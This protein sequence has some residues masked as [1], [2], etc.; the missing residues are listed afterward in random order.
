[1]QTHNICSWNYVG[2]GK[3]NQIPTVGKYNDISWDYV[4]TGTM[5]QIPTVGKY[6]AISWNYVDTDTMNR[7]PT[8]GKYNAISWNY[9]DTGTMNRPLR[10][11]EWTWTNVP[12]IKQIWRNERGQM[13][14]SL[15]RFG[16]MGTQNIYTNTPVRLIYYANIYTR[17]HQFGWFI[18]QIYISEHTVRRR[19]RFIAP[20]FQ[21]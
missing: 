13:H 4:D 6:N 19:G 18:A 11:T 7:I 20:A 9:V 8:V 17:T 10:L 1:M 14:Q 21:L 12:I 15:N 2:M 3:I 16:G 5:N